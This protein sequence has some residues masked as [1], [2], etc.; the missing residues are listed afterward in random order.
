[1][2]DLA[3]DHSLQPQSD[4]EIPRLNRQYTSQQVT[5]KSIFTL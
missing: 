2:D 1:M 3:T 5:S 4:F